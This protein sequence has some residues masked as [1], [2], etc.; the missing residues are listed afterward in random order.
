VHAARNRRNQ[1]IDPSE[2]IFLRDTIIELVEQAGLI[3]DLPTHHRRLR[4]R[5]LM[6][7]RD[8][9]SEIF[10]S[11]FRQHLPRA[12][13]AIRYAKVEDVARSRRR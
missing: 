7:H 5:G 9:C 2:Q 3:T 1:Q 6:N 13:V 8:H 12:D 4:R 10:S 11:L